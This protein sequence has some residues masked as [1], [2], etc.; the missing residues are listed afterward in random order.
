MKKLSIL[1]LAI[2][3]LNIYAFAKDEVKG[4]SEI[5]YKYNWKLTDIYTDWDEWQKDLDYVQSQIPKYLEYKG[6]LGTSADVLLDFQNFSEENSKLSSKLYVYASLSK[7]ID[8]K[9]PI[10]LT[11]LQQLQ[12]MWVEM[13]RNTTWIQTE[14]ASIPRE[15]IDKWMAENEELA[16]YE[17]DYDSFYRQLEHILDEETQRISTYYSKALSASSKIYNSLSTADME[18]HKVTLSTGEEVLASPANAS[19]IF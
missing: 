17:H 14:L 12:T 13:G 9:N 6:T 18:F 1:L 4:E 8:G 2:F 19:K 15:T 16:I 11:K 3:T 5:N 7:D 10:Y